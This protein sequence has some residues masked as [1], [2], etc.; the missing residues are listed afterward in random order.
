MLQSDWAENGSASGLKRKSRRLAL[1]WALHEVADLWKIIADQKLRSDIIVKR[2]LQMP[3]NA[4]IQHN[5]ETLGNLAALYRKEGQ[6]IKE[7][8]SLHKIS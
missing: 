3:P 6:R 2:V 5:S 1:L 7:L 8:T 4:D